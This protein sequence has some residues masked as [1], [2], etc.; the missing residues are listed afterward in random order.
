[1]SA[2]RVSGWRGYFFAVKGDWKFTA[3]AFRSSD[4]HFKS[5]M[6]CNQCLA[7]QNGP[8]AYTDVSPDAGWRFTCAV[9]IPRTFTPM[10]NALGFSWYGIMADLLHTVWLG[11][12]RDA[13]GS[14]LMDLIEFDQIHYG[15]LGTYD[16]RLGAAFVRFSAWTRVHGINST[17]DQLDLNVLAVL[18]PTMDFPCYKGKGHDA[19]VIM[20]WLADHLQE[21][22]PDFAVQAECAWGMAA[23]MHVLD[24]AGQWLTPAQAASA[25]EAGTAYLT[26]Y[27]T[28]ANKA[29]SMAK[30]RYKLKPKLHSFQ[31]QHVEN[32][33]TSAFNPRYASCW[34][35]EDMIGRLATCSRGTHP[36]TVGLRVLQRFVLELNRR[37]KL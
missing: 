25:I 12:A 3:E 19:R 14:F 13:I 32:L 28:L 33:K 24:T 20:S 7:S 1:M 31:H 4:R 18:S 10:Q 30:P 35:D 8:F 5:Q 6:I 9:G 15:E 23:Y 22:G 34:G 26:N 2:T 11:I 29:A 36:N 27:V 37:W 21:A 17:V 16:D